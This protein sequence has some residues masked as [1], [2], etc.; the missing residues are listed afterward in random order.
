MYFNPRPRAGGDAAVSVRFPGGGYFN[1]RPRAGGD[2]SPDWYLIPLLHFNPRPRAGG[3]G[4]WYGELENMRYFN[5]RPRAG[6]DRGPGR[7][8]QGG[9]I[10]IP[11]PAQGAT[12]ALS[13]SP[14]CL[15]FQSPPPR[16]GRLYARHK[17]VSFIDFNPRPRAGGD[18]AEV[19]AL[20]GKI[21]SIPAPAQGATRSVK[22]SIVPQ[23]FQSPPPRRGRPKYC[24][25]VHLRNRISIPAPAQ[26]ATYTA[27]ELSVIKDIS[28]PAPAQG[29]TSPPGPCS[30]RVG[31]SIPAPAQGATLFAEYN[32]ISV[33]ISIPAP[34][35]GATRGYGW[36]SFGPL[37]SIPAPAQGAT[38]ITTTYL[39]IYT[40]QSPPP[41]RGRQVQ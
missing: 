19:T 16:R 24:P 22:P 3:D 6:G 38:Y 17:Q 37:I 5:P 13:V 7:H 34:A 8:R 28:I 10:S 36:C 12:P 9:P 23:A 32:A 1:P 25:M 21:I 2:L 40:F 33:R 20:R 30:G 26:G 15:L 14:K 41:R 31:I 11:A 39:C 29:A 4:C 27:G 18:E 35:Q